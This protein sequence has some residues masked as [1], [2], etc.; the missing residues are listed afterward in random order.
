MG[1]GLERMSPLAVPP[2]GSP[3]KQNKAYYVKHWKTVGIVQV[4][5]GDQL[6]N[7]KTELFLDPEK[8]VRVVGGVGEWFVNPELAK[9]AVELKRGREIR[10][11][12]SRIAKVMSIEVQIR[13]WS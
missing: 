12:Q 8:K 10:L 11:L 5:R 9:R 3:P 4:Q 1:D 6:G 7:G 2:G 13:G